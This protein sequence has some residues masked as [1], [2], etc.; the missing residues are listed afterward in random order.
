MATINYQTPTCQVCG[1][2]TTL[3]LDEEK[4]RRWRAGEFAQ[5]VWPELNAAN[6]EQIISGTHL[7]CW[8]ELF[9]DEDE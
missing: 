6:R 1:N 9:G 3:M 5:D 4:V 2:S 7:D 8:E